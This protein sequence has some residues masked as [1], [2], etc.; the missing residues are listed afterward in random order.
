MIDLALLTTA[1]RDLRDWLVAR[2]IVKVED[3]QIVGTL[4]GFEFTAQG[5]PNPIQ[6]EAAKGDPNDPGYVPPV[7]DTR[8]C[9]LVRL[10]HDMDAAD[11]DKDT[12]VADDDPNPRLSRSRLVKW[13]KANGAKETL[14][15]ASGWSVTAWNIADKVWLVEA[16]GRLGAWQ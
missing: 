1:P 7:Y 8:K 14:T 12:V 10:A 6:T 13:V 2:N 4:P 15:S 5:V 16:G 9:Y 3:G 11:D